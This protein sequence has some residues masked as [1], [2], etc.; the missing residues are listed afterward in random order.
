MKTN[1]LNLSQRMEAP[2]PKF[3]KKLRNIGLMVAAVGA[4]IIASPVALPAIAIKVAGYLTVAGSVMTAVSQSTVD[5]DEKAL[6][7]AIR[8]SARQGLPSKKT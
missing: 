6:Q 3:F 2:T 8:Y 1:K 7:D 5:E 4:T